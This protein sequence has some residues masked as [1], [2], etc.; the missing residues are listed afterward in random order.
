MDPSAAWLEPDAVRVGGQ[1]WLCTPPSSFLSSS[2]PTA[3][4]S[5]Y[6]EIKTPLTHP[7]LRGI[8]CVCVCVCVWGVCV[9][10]HQPVV[11][12]RYDVTINI[13]SLTL[14]SFPAVFCTPCPHICHCNM[15]NTWLINLSVII[16]H[17][18]M[19]WRLHVILS[20]LFSANTITAG[21]SVIVCLCFISNNLINNPL[22]LFS[23]GNTWAGPFPESP[24]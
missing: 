4:L 5:F 19:Y 11:D 6:L 10:V 2:P 9:C 14:I 21:C 16:S 7:T 18:H 24:W 12:G 23:R 3:M 8:V 13:R 22:V 15:G 1:R 17:F 20:L